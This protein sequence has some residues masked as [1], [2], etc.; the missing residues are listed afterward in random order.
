MKKQS[1]NFL[2]IKNK[3]I[4][5]EIK[6]SIDQKEYVECAICGSIKVNVMELARTLKILSDKYYEIDEEREEAIADI[7]REVIEGEPDF[8]SIKDWDKWDK[9]NEHRAC[10]FLVDD[11]YETLR[12]IRYAEVVLFT[13]E[14]CECLKIWEHK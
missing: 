9:E 3:N 2:E 1:N 13:N 14:K 12:Y 8:D 7:L 4:L 5:D 11:G 6:S 10:R